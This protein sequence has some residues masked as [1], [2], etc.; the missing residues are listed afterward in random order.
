MRLS[1][2]TEKLILLAGAK[3]KS[4][5]TANKSAGFIVEICKLMLSATNPKLFRK[6]LRGVAELFREDFQGQIGKLLNI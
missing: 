5:M 1:L 4:G 3:K 6:R 2:K